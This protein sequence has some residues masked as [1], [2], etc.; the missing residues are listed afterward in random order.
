[1]MMCDFVEAVILSGQLPHVELLLKPV[2]LSVAGRAIGGALA[3]S[4]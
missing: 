3:V 2:D 1:M 4:A